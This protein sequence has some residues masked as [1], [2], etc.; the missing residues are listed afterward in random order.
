MRRTIGSTISK[1]GK[2]TSQDNPQAT[3]QVD[4]ND[5]PKPRL[6]QVEMAETTNV[7]SSDSTNGMITEA[8]CAGR[9][10]RV[11]R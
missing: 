2:A 4:R 8:Y 11:E 5:G 7:I 1:V 10:L 6:F 9:R 3:G